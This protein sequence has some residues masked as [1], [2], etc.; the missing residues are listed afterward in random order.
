M[1]GM[2]AKGPIMRA[3]AGLGGEKECSIT[4]VARLVHL[5]EVCRAIFA[6]LRKPE[7]HRCCKSPGRDSGRIGR[8]PGEDLPGTVETPV[9]KSLTRA[10][11][12]GAGFEPA[13][14]GL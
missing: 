8:D 12:A 10:F 13:T 9:S 7:G 1:G 11:V 5:E 6:L 2:N 4:V 3:D 14:F